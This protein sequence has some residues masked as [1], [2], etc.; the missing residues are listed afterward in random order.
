MSWLVGAATL[1][2]CRWSR[3]GGLLAAHQVVLTCSLSS[4]LGPS[5]LWATR[6][7]KACCLRTTPTTWRWGVSMEQDS[8]RSTHHKVRI[9]L[10][11]FLVTWVYC[12]CSNR[13]TYRTAIIRYFRPVVLCSSEWFLIARAMLL[14]GEIV[15]VNLLRLNTFCDFCEILKWL[16]HSID[17]PVLCYINIY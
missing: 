4:T 1:A 12:L 2:C 7:W 8:L 14:F 13:S 11:H 3:H 15:F 16:S 5:R 10:L 17:S 9:K 6:P